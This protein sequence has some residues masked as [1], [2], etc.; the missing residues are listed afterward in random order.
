MSQEKQESLEEKLARAH[1][2]LWTCDNQQ[3]IE[4]LLTNLE[5]ETK[6][7]MHESDK[8]VVMLQ[9]FTADKFDGFDKRGQVVFEPG[10]WEKFCELFLTAVK[11]GI[12]ES[13]QS[14]SGSVALN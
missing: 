1:R 3:S 9:S 6:I 10:T 12:V 14:D 11:G 8:Y 4:T 13:I 5:N 2:D 7:K